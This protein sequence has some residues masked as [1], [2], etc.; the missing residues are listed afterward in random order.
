MI[1]GTSKS[2]LLAQYLQSK[3][4]DFI[5]SIFINFSAQTQVNQFQDLLDSKFEKRRRGVFGPPAGKKL[6]LFVDDI[7]MPQKEFYGA[8]PPIEL[9]RQWMD[10]DGWYN[11]KELVM[12]QIIDIVWLGAMGPPGGA[13]FTPTDS[14]YKYSQE[15]ILYTLCFN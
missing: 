4:P 9:V 12:M 11:R 13:I 1:S 8:Q 5:S 2:L 7:N 3:A 6:V 14:Y 15:L 10:H